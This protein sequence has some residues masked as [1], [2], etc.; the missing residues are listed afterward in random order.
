MSLIAYA[1]EIDIL[2]HLS[3]FGLGVV[4]YIKGNGRCVEFPVWYLWVAG[5][6][7]FMHR[8]EYISQKGE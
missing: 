1:R 2:I 6:L 7:D 4:T 8:Q 3:L 5:R